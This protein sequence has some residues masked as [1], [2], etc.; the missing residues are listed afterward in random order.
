MY[1]DLLAPINP[2]LKVI[3]KVLRMIQYVL[4]SR[5]KEGH[6]ERIA[7]TIYKCYHCPDEALNPFACPDNFINRY[8]HEEDL[9][10]WPEPK[11]F[12]EKATGL[13]TGIAPLQP[14]SE[15]Y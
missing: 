4:Y 2:S 3:G 1:D 11:V 15:D 7:H 12:W 5:T 14:L 13:S 8:M 9:V 10:G 6:I